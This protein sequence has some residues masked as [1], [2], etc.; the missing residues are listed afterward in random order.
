MKKY[1][2]LAGSMLFASF[3]MQ[4]CLDFDDP[5]DELGNGSMQLETTIH[6]GTVDAINYKHLP[7]EA[8]MKEAIDALKKNG[9]LGQ[10]LTG[11]YNM[12]GGKEN[13]MPGGHAYQRQ[14]SLGPDLYAQYF[15]LPHKDYMYGT[16]TSTYNVSAEFNNGPLGAYG[17]AKN[18]FMPLLHHPM[19]DSIPEIKAINL[20]YYCLMA[21]ENADLSGPFTYLEDKENS[22]D[23]RNYNDLETIYY[24]IVENLDTIVACLKHYETERPDWYK[25]NIVGILDAYHQ[26]SRSLLNG[27]KTMN[28]YIKLANSLKLRMA[29]HIVKVQ[30]EIAKK[31]AEEAVASGVIESTEEQQGLYPM[32]SGF[33]HPLMEIQGWGD[34]CFSASF[35]GLLKSL[36]HPYLKYFVLRNSNEIVDR[37]TGEKTPAN[38]DFYGIREGILVGNG[39]VYASNQYQAYSKFDSNILGSSLAPLYFV[40]FAEVDFLRAEGVLRGWNMGEEGTT[41]EFFYNRGIENA[42]FEDPL[43]GPQYSAYVKDYMAL[44]SPINHTVKDPIGDGTWESFTKIGVKWNEGDDNETKLEKIITQKYIALFPLST[45]AWAEMR[46]TGYPRLLPVL[47]PDDGD[48]SLENG[49]IIRRIPWVPTDPIA[50]EIVESSGTTALG[51]YDEQATRLWWDVNKSNF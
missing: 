10:S 49:D 23:P 31:W 43:T 24:G 48:G 37:R 15:V 18:V 33:A 35:I 3:V 50:I 2:M 44:E 20:L 36:D 11:Q 34:L 17:M 27:D 26:T 4:S 28:S 12:R 14:Y 30:P 6:K 40:K 1:I 25:Q 9:Y 42:Y 46:R 38:D 41:A 13:G 39:Q 32:V 51:G 16:H 47:N 22:I 45:E 8:G 29:M 21:Q 5:G 7:T 19:V